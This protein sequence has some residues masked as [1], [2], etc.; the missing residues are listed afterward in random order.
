[1]LCPTLDADQDNCSRA[2]AFN[3]FITYL[4][5]AAR[6]NVTLQLTVSFFLL[7]FLIN[8]TNTYA[9]PT[10]YY[11]KCCTVTFSHFLITNVLNSAGIRLAL[12]PWSW[13]CLHKLRHREKKGKM[14]RKK[15]NRKKKYIEW[16]WMFQTFFF[17]FISPCITATV[18]ILTIVVVATVYLIIW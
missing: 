5:A 18:T 11:K 8:R 14:Q 2:P 4:H 9:Q 16:K 6:M 3:F 10:W 7:S 17:H 15:K 13:K 1:M 12:K